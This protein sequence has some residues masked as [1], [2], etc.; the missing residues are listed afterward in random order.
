MKLNE[1]IADLQKLREQIPKDEN[2]EVCGSGCDDCCSPSISQSL[3][4]NS[5]R[6]AVVRL[7]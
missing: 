6:G 4:E 5:R 7:S 2:P 1:L 3:L